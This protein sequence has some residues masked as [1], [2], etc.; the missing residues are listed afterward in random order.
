M[1]DE[2]EGPLAPP[3]ANGEVLFEAPW[4]GRVFGMARALCEA[5]LYTWDEFRAE[6]IREIAHWDREPAGE[7][8]YYDHFQRAL[9]RLLA[10]KGMLADAQLERRAELLRAR[11]HGHDH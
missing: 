8:R 2:L 6:L 5:G 3:M 4:Q 1:T 11:P 10:R 7:Y 9:E